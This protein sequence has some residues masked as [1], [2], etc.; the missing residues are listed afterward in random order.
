[1]FGRETTGLP[2]DVKAE[3][4]SLLTVPMLQPGVRCLNLASAVAI[5]LSEA[6]RQLQNPLHD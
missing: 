2:A 6:L 1:L 3:C 5:V 4:D